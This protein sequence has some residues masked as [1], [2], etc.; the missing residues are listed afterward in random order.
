MEQTNNKDDLKKQ[1]EILDEIKKKLY[2]NI[3]DYTKEEQ[4]L[5]KKLDDIEELK[6]A[7]YKNYLE[8][9]DE[10]FE[11]HT[12]IRTEETPLLMELFNE[13]LQH[14]YKPSNMYWVAAKTKNKIKEDLLKTLN[15]E[16]K[17]MLEQI[18]FCEDRILDDMTE[19]AYIFGYATSIQLREEATKQYPSKKEEF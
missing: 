6:K 3:K 4:E 17:H 14:I 5:I 12:K 2:N 9:F 1:L 13:F 16:Q 11:T 19:Q 8:G 18:E 10:Q 15:D 7:N